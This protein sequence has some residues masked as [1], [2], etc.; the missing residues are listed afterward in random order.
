MRREGRM[1][2]AA[3]TRLYPLGG[4]FQTPLYHLHPC[5]RASMQA[6]ARKLKMRFSTCFKTS[7]LCH[8]QI[9][10]SGATHPCVA[11]NS[12]LIRVSNILCGARRPKPCGH[13]PAD[14]DRQ[15]LPP[16]GRLL[17]CIVRSQLS[18][19][20][21]QRADHGTGAVA[22]DQHMG[23]VTCGVFGRKD[24]VFPLRCQKVAD[25]LFGGAAQFGKIGP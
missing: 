19:P 8:C 2:V 21:F 7:D 12:E 6:R 9:I 25:D 3:Q 22:A 23:R 20:V 4:L 13:P 11:G 1:P 15:A 5:R 17:N 14:H 18:Q 10:R 16:V 24:E